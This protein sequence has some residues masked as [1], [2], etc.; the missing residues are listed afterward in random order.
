[1]KLSFFG[2]AGMVTGSCFLVETGKSK[3]LVDCGLF[4]GSKDV[5]RLNFEPFGFNPKRFLILS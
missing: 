4:Q 2:A 3:V 5:N 1:M